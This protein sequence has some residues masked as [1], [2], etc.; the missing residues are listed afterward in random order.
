MRYGRMEREVE[1]MN[2]R[3]WIFWPEIHVPKGKA[4]LPVH[5]LVAKT[6][7]FLRSG[8]PHYTLNIFCL[9]E[10]H[11]EELELICYTQGVPL[12]VLN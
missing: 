1:L 6:V 3:N 12:P 10:L 8:K 4:L 5:S 7:P 9:V 2:E 11:D